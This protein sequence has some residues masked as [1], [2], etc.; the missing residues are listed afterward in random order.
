MP[1]GDGVATAL[2]I[3]LGGRDGLHQSYATTTDDG[4]TLLVLS[5]ADDADLYLPEGP[6]RF[7]ICKPAERSQ[8]HHLP[9]SDVDFSQH[10]SSRDGTDFSVEARDIALPVRLFLPVMAQAALLHQPCSSV[11]SWNSGSLVRSSHQ[12][13]RC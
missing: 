9:H 11:R 4:R 7:V 10:R 1:A 12:V 5:H 8:D 2:G 13:M 3:W 6:V